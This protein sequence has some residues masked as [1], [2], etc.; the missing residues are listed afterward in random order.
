MAN[1]QPSD[2][3][4]E[5]VINELIERV[6]KLEKKIE[7]FNTQFIGKVQ[8]V[9]SWHTHLMNGDIHWNLPKEMIEKQV[10]ALKEKLDQINITK[11]VVTNK[12]QARP[13]D[14]FSFQVKEVKESEI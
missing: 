6:N 1:M 4:E 5:P 10:Q 12:E 8:Q 13:S 14:S 3:M 9:I 7:L 11:K 2:S